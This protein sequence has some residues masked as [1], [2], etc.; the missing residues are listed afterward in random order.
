MG[1]LLNDA[2]STSSPPP[3]T[4]QLPRPWSDH[5]GSV[6]RGKLQEGATWKNQA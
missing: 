2:F 6:S 4:F 5:P 3:R 1:G